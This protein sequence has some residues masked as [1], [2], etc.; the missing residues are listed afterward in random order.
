MH[1]SLPLSVVIPTLDASAQLG[2]A[3]AAI[4]SERDLVREIIVADGGSLDATVELARSYG[5]RVI[6]AP[7]GR[8]TQL[9]AGA[10]RAQG[11]WLMFLHADTRLEAGWSA[12]LR[13]FIF[14]PA[15]RGRAGYFRFRL[16]DK[17]SAAL[18]LERFVAWRCHV[19]GLPYGD[20]GLVL[21]RELY[22]S[23]G[24]FPPLPLMEDVALVRRIG[25]RRLV[26]LEADAVTSAA[27]YRREGYGRRSLRNLGCLGCYFMGVP[28]RL[29][30]RLYG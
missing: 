7:C 15:N 26:P 23:L 17:S 1:S 13:R 6:E 22:L 20:Q 18:R 30:L 9:G 10:D 3:L 2:A 8:G 5:A 19:L 28:P 21:E 12:V 25:K 24:G 29:I 16:D 27:R 4:E 11:E 14:E